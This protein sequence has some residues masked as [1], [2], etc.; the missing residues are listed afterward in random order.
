[1][2]QQ[3]RLVFSTI[4]LILAG[5]VAAFVL[6]GFSG[7]EQVAGQSDKL[8]LDADKAPYQ[9]ILT[10]G[11]YKIPDDK[12]DKMTVLMCDIDGDGVN[13]WVQGNHQKLLAHDSEDSRIKPRWELHLEDR[14]IFDDESTRLGLGV[15]LDG[16]GTEEVVFTVMAEDNSGWNYCVLDPITEKIIVNVPLPLGED[17]RRPDYWDGHYSTE[18]FL[19]DADGKGNPGVV[20]LRI[21]KYDATLRGVCVVEPFT[22]KVIWEYE[23]G[24]QPG[25][26][27]IAV[28]DVDGDGSREIIFTTSAPNNWGDVVIN[29]TSDRE[30]YLIA[31][32]NQGEVLMKEVIGG[33]RFYGKL[34]VEDLDGD[35]IKELV[36]STTNGNTGRTN[37]LTVWDWSTKNIIRMARSSCNFMGMAITHGPR[38]GTSYIFTGTDDGTFHRYLY[39]GRTLERDHVVLN[40]TRGCNLLGAV[41]ILPPEGK[42]IVVQ[43][44]NG[45]QTA[46]LDRNLATL[47]IYDDEHELWKSDPLVWDLAP[48][49]KA[50]FLSHSKSYWVLEFEKKPFD[51]AGVL[52]RVGLPVL[53]LFFLAVAFYFGRITGR[54]NSVNEGSAPKLSASADFDALFRL[55]QELEDANHSV[56]GQTKG[57][58]RLVWLLEAYTTDLGVSDEL[59]SRIHQV[60]DDYQAEVNPRLLRLLRLADQ[61]SFEMETVAATHKAMTSLS[62]IIAELADQPINREGII[63]VRPDLRKDWETV[64]DGFLKLRT[65]IN[66]YFTTDPVRLVKG[67]LLIR[68][69]DFQRGRIKTRLDGGDDQSRGMGCRVDNGDLRFVMDNLLDNAVRAMKEG[70]DNQLTVQISRSGTEITLLVTDTGQGIHPD[71]QCEIFSSRYSSRHGGGR[72]LHRSREILARWGAEIQLGDSAPGKGTTFIVKLLAAAEE[73]GPKSLEAHG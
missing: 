30:S 31:L 48:D 66:Q 4:L 25:S 61:A 10:R 71:Q 11:G 21:V 33:E 45:R 26:K 6:P 60:L 41:D 72:G 53:G 69:G 46:I 67:M 63:L 14:F 40:Q 56:V 24:A 52:V 59:E 13:E 17:R 23:C 32:S 39:D 43:V 19:L 57:L 35:G 62:L 20:L 64:K 68:E 54:R 12:P 47:A 42:E 49:K 8:S 22:G 50:L 38:P 70:A 29:G 15:D 16:D 34:L 73:K 55:Q 44:D 1:M 51:M 28:V 7:C 65:A 36:T 2:S 5:T 9:I 18:G 27:Q 58:E 3:P 37:E